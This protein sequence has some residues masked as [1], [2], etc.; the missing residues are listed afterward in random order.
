MNHQHSSE[1]RASSVAHT[2]AAVQVSGHDLRVSETCSVRA[3]LAALL[4]LVIV[5]AVA[6]ALVGCSNNAANLTPGSQTP[7]ISVAMQQNPPADM[8]TGTPTQVSAVVTN[9]PANAGVDWVV[10]CGNTGESACGSF[11][12]AHTAAGANTI[13]TAPAAVPPQSTL[14]IM[15]L[16]TTDHSKFASVS[17]TITSTVTGIVILSQPP[18]SIPANAFVNFSAQVFG[19]PAN[20]GVTWTATCTTASGPLD[21]SGN[22]SSKSG[23][24]IILTVPQAITFTAA[25]ILQQASLVGTPITI[26]AFPTAD[27]KWFAQFVFTVTAP[28]SLNITQ[29][30][31]ATILTNTTAQLIAVVANDTLNDGVTWLVNCTGATGSCGSITPTQTGSGG[32]ATYTAP[33]SVPS[34]SAISISAIATATSLGTS[35]QQITVTFNIGAPISVSITQGINNNTLTESASAPLIAT[36]SNDAANA[37]V[38]WTVTC[39]SAGACGTFSFAHTA[40]GAPT[41]YTAPNAP[42][43]GNTVTILATSTTDPTK[44]NQLIV[45]IT[46]APPPNSLL[47]GQFILF[48]SGKNSQN[49][50][51][52]LGGALSGDGNGNVIAGKFD[53]ADAAGNAVPANGLPAVSPSTYSIGF[54]GRGQ[55]QLTLNTRA[56]NTNFGVPV[57]GGTTSTLTLSVV[58]VTP[59]HALVTEIDAFGNGTGTLDLQNAAD[60]A[61]FGNGTAGLN[62]TYSLQLTGTEL[63]NPPPGFFVAAAITSQAAGVSYTFTGYTA[64]QSANGVITSVPFT[65]GSQTFQNSAPSTI[66]EIFL[67]AVNLGLP[68]PFNLDLWL[69][70]ANHFV[71]TD[72]I[73]ATTGSFVLVGGYLTVQPASP[74]LSGTFAFTEAGSTT[75][76]Q[77]QVAGGILSCGSSGI[78]DVV[79]LAGT[80]LSNQS[81]STTCSAPV[82]GR[83][84]ISI[85]GAGSTG[86][87]QFA[88]YPTLDQGIY[89]MELDGGSSGTSGPS[90]AGLALQQTLPAPISASSFIGDY[91]SNFLAATALGSQNFAAQIISDGVSALS[92]AA[93]VNSFNATAVPRVSSPSSSA[94]LTGSF[95]A[96]PNGRF[97][98]TLMITPASGQPTP[99]ITTLPSA[100]YIV[101]ANTC[102]L[103]GLDVTAPGTGILRL[104]HTGL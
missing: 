64:D 42:P 14:T 15:A 46:N 96:G 53:L 58:F 104:Q 84:L 81:V 67:S 43:S 68:K 69:I 19:D 50:P 87:S 78:L 23:N 20:L 80:P 52:V 82:N 18:P 13:F 16:S 60:L 36:V 27:H 89:L 7:I 101:D 92:G 62:G 100:C 21:C 54:D 1:H 59:Q 56:L 75:A 11:S 31:P 66:G 91:A 48:L 72:F 10:T 17:V 9:D 32:T 44:S 37:G 3:S 24:S 103:I 88:A 71:V 30:P 4:A 29:P 77:P 97:P 40:S 5:F 102:L 94:T 98:L 8:V 99:Q 34:P 38:D 47:Q 85:S 63:M 93:D 76:A 49:G 33:S 28:I 2:G 22:F 61:S 51:F 70:D 26:T 12:P 45:T 86:I 74:S 57:P 39:G 25:G 83:G 95:T 65:A 41:T 35:V 6:C 73:D 55:I 79:S 90:G